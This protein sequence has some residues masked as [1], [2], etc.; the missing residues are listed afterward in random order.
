MSRTYIPVALRRLVSERANGRCE[1]CLV[2]QAYSL[3]LHHPDHI[4][5]EQ[6]GGQTISENLAGACIECNYRKGPNIASVDPITNQIVPLFNPRLN[7]WQ[8]HFRLEG[9]H[10]RALTPIGRATLQLLQ[11]NDTLRLDVRQAM[12]EDNDLLV[13]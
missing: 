7:H 8:E 13:P 5:A 3:V 10:I 9:A 4:I 1:Y 12:L 11:F 6:H 2:G